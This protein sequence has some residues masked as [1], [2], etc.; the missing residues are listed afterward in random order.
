MEW[1]HT[2]DPKV[3]S[4]YSQEWLKRYNRHQPVPSMAHIQV[5]TS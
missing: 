2:H 3:I 1:S 5:F 4:Y